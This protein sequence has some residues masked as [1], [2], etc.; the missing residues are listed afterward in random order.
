MSWWGTVEKRAQETFS[1]RDGTRIFVGDD[2]RVRNSQG[3][4]SLSRRD[5]RRK[6]GY[7][8]CNIFNHNSNMRLK[9]SSCSDHSTPPTIPTIFAEPVFDNAPEDLEDEDPAAVS[10]EEAVPGEVEDATVPRDVEV[11]D[12][13]EDAEDGCPTD[14]EDVDEVAPAASSVV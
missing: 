6:N 9:K 1:G 8:Q 4:H 2:V 11:E 12:P 13:L 7:M 14:A 5:G 10:E 3:I